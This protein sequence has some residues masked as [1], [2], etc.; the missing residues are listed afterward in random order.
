LNLFANKRFRIVPENITLIQRSLAGNGEILVKAGQEVNPQEIIG[1]SIVSAGFRKINLSQLLSVSPG[2]VKKHLQRVPGKAIYKGELLA[3]R[4]SGLFS[5]KKIVQSPTDGIIELLDENTGILKLKIL[6]QKVDL[7]AAVYGIIE[8]VDHVKKEITIKTQ[9]TQIYGILGSGR[10]REG[11]LKVLGG[12][13]DLISKNDISPDLNDKIIVGGGLIYDEGLKEAVIN[14]V[15]GIITGGINAPDFKG[16]SGG[17]IKYAH[18]ESEVGIGVLVTEGFGTIPIGNDIFG[19]LKEFDNKFV[20]L[21]GNR[22]RVNLPSTREDSIISIRKVYKFPSN[23]SVSVVTEEVL[24]PGKFVRIIGSPNMG[25]QGKIISIDKIATT[26]P[27]G[28]V[29]YMITI[30]TNTRKIRIPYN[31]VEI[32]NSSF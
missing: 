2:E 32:I 25:E 19:L 12:M 18:S 26:L 8:R 10:P 27:S 23:D 31:N 22:G 13:G 5:G 14:G 30:S 4:G 29:T 21:E 20:I 9:V 17:K 11:Y 6:P 24:D 1:R 15:N 7:P 28:V 16:M 3:Y